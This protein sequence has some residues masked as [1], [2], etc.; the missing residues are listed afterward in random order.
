MSPLVARAT[1]RESKRLE[2]RDDLRLSPESG[3]PSAGQKVRTAFSV[4]ESPT[5]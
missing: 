2:R 1:P 4:R 3:E 5:V